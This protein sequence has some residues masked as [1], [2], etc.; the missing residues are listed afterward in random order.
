[1]ARPRSDEAR[2][3][4]L[5]ATRD[6]IVDNGV[7]NLTIE[8]VAARSGVAK[9]TIYRHWP[10]R[11]SLIVDAVNAMFEHLRTPDTGSLRGDLESFFGAVMHTDLSGNVGQIMPSIIE[12]AGRDPE[13]AYLLERVG[14]E[15]ERVCRTI[16]ERALE[17]GEIRDDMARLGLEALIG[18]TV[19]PIVFQKI[20]RRRT[21]TPEYVD[22]CLDVVIAGLTGG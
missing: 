18:V 12:A 10:E 14:S 17:R 16:I 11:T 7:I 20:V 19:G 5:E 3:K 6:L 8:D 2:R 9:T 4:A 22:A 1:M 21:L 15:R 13:M